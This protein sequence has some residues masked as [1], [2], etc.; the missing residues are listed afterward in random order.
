[1]VQ[2]LY[3]KKKLFETPLVGLERFD[4]EGLAVVVEDK[5]G[6]VFR[7]VKNASSTALIAKGC[8]LMKLTTVA[9]D[10]HKRVLSPN[11]IGTGPA[12]CLITLP[13]GVPMTGIAKSGSATGDHGF[14]L[15]DGTI[16]VSIRQTATAV[17]GQ[18]GNHSI[19]T[20][21]CVTNSEWGAPA[22][23][24]INSSGGTVNFRGVQIMDPEYSLTTGAATVASAIVH[25]HCK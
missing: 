24:V 20:T 2:T 16:K 22:S 4:V 14:V 8:C 12:T 11:A 6:N 3:P 9:D 18:A 10:V 17:Q 15:I 25:V 19:A 23:S 1:M 5:L 21:I 7:W 13:A